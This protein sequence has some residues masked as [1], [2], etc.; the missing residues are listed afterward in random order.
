MFPKFSNVNIE[1]HRKVILLNSRISLESLA[2]Q[3]KATKDVDTGL[4]QIHR[5]HLFFQNYISEGIINAVA[6][7]DSRRKFL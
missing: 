2:M 1:I 4:V 6:K 5:A 3:L 7:Y